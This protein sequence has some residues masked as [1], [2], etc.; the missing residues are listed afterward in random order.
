MAYV[1]FDEFPECGG[2]EP[3]G[4]FHADGIAEHCH[5]DDGER[6]GVCERGEAGERGEGVRK[7]EGR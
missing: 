7:A 3:S 4:I 5:Y 1:D 6:A 2:D